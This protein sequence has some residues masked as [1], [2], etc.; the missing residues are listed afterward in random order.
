VTHSLNT[1]SQSRHTSICSFVK[2]QRKSQAF[3][4]APT[5]SHCQGQVALSPLGTSLSLSLSLPLS[6][7]LCV[8]HTLLSLQGPTDLLESAALPFADWSS[9]LSSGRQALMDS[10]L[11]LN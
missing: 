9:P 4:C 11:S 10:R 2:K 1:E 7:S 3:V 8:C 6:L 5:P